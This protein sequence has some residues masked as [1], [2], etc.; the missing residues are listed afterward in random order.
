MGQSWSS[1]A[2]APLIEDYETNNTFQHAKSGFYYRMLR[3][4]GK[5]IQQRYLLDRNQQPIHVHEEEVTYVV[6][7]GNH[8]RYY[9]RHHPNGVITQLPV[10]WY[11][12]KKRWDIA[13]MTGKAPTTKVM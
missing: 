7:S 10:T 5:F 6:G 12:Q 13:G 8:A 1:P 11:S 2:S 3:K 4:D 9:L